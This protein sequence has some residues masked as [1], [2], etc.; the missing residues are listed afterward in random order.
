MLF[1]FNQ[2]AGLAKTKR[3]VER[4]LKRRLSSIVLHHGT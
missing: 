2:I 1:R 4:L 3:C